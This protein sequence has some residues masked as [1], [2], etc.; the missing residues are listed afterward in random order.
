MWGV[1]GGWWMGVG[2]GRY[3][4]TL[5]KWR[6]TVGTTGMRSW[7][8]YLMRLKRRCEVRTGG[9]RWQRTQTDMEATRLRSGE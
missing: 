4:G 6:S 3:V 8:Y 7:G 2:G 9:G 5:E 1:D